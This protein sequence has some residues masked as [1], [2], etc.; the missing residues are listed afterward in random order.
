MP[1]KTCAFP[2]E[3][4]VRDSHWIPL[5]STQISLCWAHGVQD[6]VFQAVLCLLLL[7]IWKEDKKKGFLYFWCI[8]LSFFI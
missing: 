5:S 7:L 4:L 8:L 6:E 1:V 2:L 3:P